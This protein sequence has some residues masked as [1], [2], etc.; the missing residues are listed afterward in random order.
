M[1]S[2][3]TNF[4]SGK[5]LSSDAAREDLELSGLH[6]DD[7]RQDER[8]ACRITNERDFPVPVTASRCQD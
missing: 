2:S 6:V 3:M 4:T 8:Q 1:K 7:Q 5:A